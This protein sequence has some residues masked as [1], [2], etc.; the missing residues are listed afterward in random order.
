[1]YLYGAWV[2]GFL[3]DT[4]HQLVADAALVSITG[5]WRRV[6]KIHLE[7]GGRAEEGRRIR[8]MQ[9]VR[10]VPLMLLMCED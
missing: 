2:G 8:V 7:G 5:C 6:A 4:L 9:S 1:M 3:V 10:I